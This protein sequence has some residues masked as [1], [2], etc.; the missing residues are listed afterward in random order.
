MPKIRLYSLLI[1]SLAGYV[2]IGYFIER[3]N[4][5]LLITTYSSL[6]LISYLILKNKRHYNFKVLLLSGILFRLCLIFSTPSLSDDFYRFLWDGR[7]QQLGFNPFDFTPRQFLNQNSDAF[8]N[9]LFPYLNSPDYFSVYPQLSQILFNIVSVIGKDSLQ[10]NL[11]VMKSMIFLTE[12]GTLY[13]LNKLANKRKQDPS[14]LLIYL[15]NPLVIIELTGN[16]HLEAFMIFFFL[17]AVMLFDRQRFIGSATALS[18]SVQTKLLPI[19]VIPFLI[20]KIGIRKTIGYGLVCVLITA[21]ISIES[22]NTSDRISHIAE[23]LN[24]YYGKFEFNGG[25]YLFFRSIGWTVLGYNPIAILSKLMILFTLAGILFVYL[26]DSDILSGFFWVLIIYLG[27]AAIIHPWYLTPLVA[28]SIFVR[29][30]FILVWSALIPLSYISYKTL[31]Y[32]ENYWITGLEY[33]I[34][35]GYLLWEVKIFFTSSKPDDLEHEKFKKEANK[36]I[37]Y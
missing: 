9:Q 8:L 24:L 5:E 33:L 36:T 20:K 4:F 28:L 16:I 19:L 26:K 15:L 3:S 17:L 14:H 37:E 21:I 22:I 23:S 31:P 29:F 13:L 12:I 10:T 34:V 1:L 35:M 7:I 2:L 18:L 32:S 11:I 25:I 27:F 30:R 6:F